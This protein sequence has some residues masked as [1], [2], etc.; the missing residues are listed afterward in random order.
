MQQD[1]FKLYITPKFQEWVVTRGRA[2][3]KRRAA[4]SGL[5]WSG[6]SSKT[7]GQRSVPFQRTCYKG[8]GEI[9]VSL[10]GS[11]LGW[12]RVRTRE[13]LACVMRW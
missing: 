1:D 2:T 13:S 4:Y 5:A 9:P 12:N 11:G 6:I 10:L 7:S 8:T 3:A